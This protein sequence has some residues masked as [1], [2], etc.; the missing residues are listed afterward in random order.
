[1]V[2]EILGE[3]DIA[4]H[5]EGMF[6]SKKYANSVVAS[7]DTIFLSQLPDRREL[8]E[9]ILAGNIFYFQ[10]RMGGYPRKEFSI[11]EPSPFITILNITKTRCHEDS[12]M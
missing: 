6:N 11:C 10:Y 8:E 4:K 3:S 1:M 5:W 2:V 9:F 7:I 12:E